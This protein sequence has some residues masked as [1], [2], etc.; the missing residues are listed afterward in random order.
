MLTPV[1]HLLT[2]RLAMQ[3][4][5]GDIGLGLGLVAADEAR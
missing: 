5:G 1:R 4:R 2:R 3:S